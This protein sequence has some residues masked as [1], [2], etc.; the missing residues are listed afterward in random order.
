MAKVFWTESGRKLVHDRCRAMLADWPTPY[1]QIRVPRCQGE[2]FVLAF[3]PDRRTAKVDR[4]ALDD[5][6]TDVYR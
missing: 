4:L 5:S 2:T 3:W 6:D 1:E